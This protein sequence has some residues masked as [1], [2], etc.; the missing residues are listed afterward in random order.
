MLQPE[1][2]QT[3]NF[4]SYGIFNVVKMI[5][6]ACRGSGGQA[7]SSGAPLHVNDLIGQVDKLLELGEAGGLME[8]V[9]KF[10]DKEGVFEFIES[11]LAYSP[12]PFDAAFENLSNGSLELWQKMLRLL[13]CD[14]LDS[15]ACFKLFIE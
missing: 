5:P 12:R 6:Y 9:E 2:Y 15:I 7:S 11:F 13:W 1:G 8:Y 4:F 3:L 14:M 10:G